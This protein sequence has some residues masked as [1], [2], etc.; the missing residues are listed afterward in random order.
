VTANRVGVLGG[1]FNPVHN[2][3]LHLAA[4]SRDIL[5]LNEIHFVVAGIPPHKPPENLIPFH[6]R[7]AMVS[8]ATAGCSGL[9][10]S[11][12]E[13]EPPA[14]SFTFETLAKL[15]RR[16]DMSGEALYFIAGGDS[17]LEVAG[18]H[19]SELLLRSYNFVFITRPGVNLVNPRSVL[20]DS[21]AAR[22]IDCRNLAQD[23]ARAVAAAGMAATGCRIFL[24]DAGAPDIAASR[25]R[26]LAAAGKPIGHLVPA[27]VSEY[28]LKLHL[29]GE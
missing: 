18:W 9:L 22:V 15:A 23:H 10:P 8:L 28:I 21:A 4:C 24:L 26:A 2:G 13:L 6:H 11:Q 16:F 12:V 17:L 27:T 5:G 19:R 14:S 29:Y 3:H 1:S 7:Y 20:S 25:V